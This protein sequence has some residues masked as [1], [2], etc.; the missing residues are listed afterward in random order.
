[1]ANRFVITNATIVDGTGADPFTGTVVVDGDRIA[2]VRHA[3]QHR[4][5]SVEGS[6]E[7]TIDGSGLIVA[8]GFIDVHTHDDIAV[9]RRPEHGCKT[10]QGVTSVVVGNCGISPT[11]P[12]D[13]NALG[14]A[15][16]QTMGGYLRAVDQAQP[17]VN[18]A[19]LVG[20]GTI[21]SAVM[22]LRNE[23]EPTDEQL[24]EML[25]VLR[26]AFDDG[27]VGWS[28]GLAYEPGRYSPASELRAF[29]EVAADCGAIY[30]T[31]MR[32][33][34]D[35]LLASIDESIELAESAGLRLQISHL[36]AAG[37][38]VWGDVVP[39]LERIDAAR[40]RGVD[41]MADQYPYT[42]G[43]TLLEQI[44][45][46]GAFEGNSSFA[47]ITPAQV[48]VASAPGH[49]EWEGKDLEEI[50]AANDTDPREMADMIVS[51]EGRDCIVV[52]DNMSEDDVRTVLAHP[53]VMVGSD[54]IP[55]GRKPHPRLGH[56][57]P[58]IL[59]RYVRDEAL[60]ELPDM[61]R[62]MTSVP[63]ER[64]GFVDRGE[65]RAGAYADLVLFNFDTIM[66]TG[67]WTEPNAVPAGIHGVWVNGER[68][69]DDS[70]VTGAR[71]G[72][73]IRA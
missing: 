19:A 37:N 17:A 56:T 31:H 10:L 29:A 23:A 63:A 54:G 5:P 43:S 62:R 7:S 71:P 39:A 45:R 35:E 11:P 46:A 6:A 30:T 55:A 61:I 18:V 58:R 49:P 57:Y 12:A 42:R 28:T 2:G 22:G 59:G 24:A 41:V 50:A 20:H 47:K 33:E 70:S 44:V 8:P 60:V 64:F 3:G 67:T 38:E 51:T 21:R 26:A 13:D 65:I 72:R 73:T 52:L 48:L 68:V 1:M 53:A 66:D 15:S 27:A 16:H 14:P 25:D 9:L 40:A 36:K 69:V 32:N 4:T 34:S